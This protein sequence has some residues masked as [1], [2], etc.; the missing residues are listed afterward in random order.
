MRP[1]LTNRVAWSVGWSV[2]HTSESCKN[3]WSNR[4]AIW[5]EHSGGSL[6]LCVRWGSRSPMV[7]TILGKGLPI[8]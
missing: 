8:V 5:V 6:E 4:G 1:I 3:G 2:C 7:W